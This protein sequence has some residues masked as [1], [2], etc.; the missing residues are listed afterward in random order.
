M[1]LSNAEMQRIYESMKY[2]NDKGVKDTDFILAFEK[3]RDLNS[4]KSSFYSFNVVTPKAIR[5]Q[6][7]RDLSPEAHDFIERRINE[8]YKNTY[9]SIMAVLEGHRKKVDSTNDLYKK[10]PLIYK[11][12]IRKYKIDAADI[13][14]FDE[15]FECAFNNTLSKVS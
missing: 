8:G 12:Y 9:H 7:Y 5:Q 6:A 14:V 4:K 1:K 15:I 10:K 11:N 3:I 2:I 13:A